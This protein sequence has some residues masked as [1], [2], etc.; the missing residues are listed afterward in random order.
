MSEQPKSVALDLS[1]YTVPDDLTS[2]YDALQ[3]SSSQALRSVAAGETEIDKQW[4]LASRL[5]RQFLAATEEPAQLA[6]ASK[7]GDWEKAR[8]SHEPPTEPYTYL[9]WL[10]AQ[11]WRL[12]QLCGD[13]DT[14]F[15]LIDPVRQFAREGIIAA[16]TAP[17]LQRVLAQRAAKGESNIE[18][19]E[20]GPALNQSG[21][22]PGVRHLR[23]L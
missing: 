14:H 4:R 10:A 5:G 21:Q 8:A 11:A 18:E 2:L 1:K 19:R 16:K 7:L 17:S 13:E 9:L 23:S 12:L 3:E 20:R 15:S 6:L 22:A